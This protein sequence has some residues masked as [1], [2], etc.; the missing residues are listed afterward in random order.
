[1][2]I[3]I[4][5][6]PNIKKDL[7]THLTNILRQLAKHKADI[8]FNIDDQQ[9]ISPLIGKQHKNKIH[10][11][12]YQDVI[13]K[14]SMIISLGGDGT[15]IGIARSLRK[16]TPPIFAVNLG[17]LGFITEFSKIDYYE[18]LENAL[19][20]KLEFLPLQLF[21]TTVYRNKKTVFS[22][23]FVND[24]V[25]GRTN[26]TRMFTLHVESNSSTIYELSGD[27]LIISSPTGSTAYS[28]AA[29][30]PIVEPSVKAL[31]LTPICP[32]SLTHRPL[33]INDNSIISIKT[34]ATNEPLT[35]TL[36]GQESF[37]TMAGDII[38]T[39]KSRGHS[40]NLYKNPERQYFQTLRDKF[41]YGRR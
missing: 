16:L 14:V 25:L 27:G 41:T 22:G 15:L 20:S 23:H 35:V 39:R 12:S 32:H 2:N 19:K 24:V 4:I 11:V 33:I 29:G 10:F 7:N 28:L 26:M 1:M 21:K 38:E 18:Y 8:F 3:G 6:K 31:A 17:K 40:V 34:D 37:E 13:K 5:L 9:R 36:D 30:G